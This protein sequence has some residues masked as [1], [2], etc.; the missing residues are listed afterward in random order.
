MTLLR[1]RLSR[2]HCRYHEF[3][4]WLRH[5]QRTTNHFTDPSIL[6]EQLKLAL[7]TSGID[8]SPDNDPG[9]VAAYFLDEKLRKITG[10]PPN[11]HPRGS[12][13]PTRQ[14]F[15]IEEDIHSAS[16]NTCREKD[17]SIRRR[18]KKNITHQ[19]TAIKASHGR[20]AVHMPQDVQTTTS[21]P[22]P[23]SIDESSR[24]QGHA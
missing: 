20:Y 9:E 18:R 4:K 8:D 10:A 2:I 13:K 23:A 5:P 24:T 6:H 12:P 21:T 11:Y 1:S 3:I 14:L 19:D 17:T 15:W 7:Q 22:L 16:T